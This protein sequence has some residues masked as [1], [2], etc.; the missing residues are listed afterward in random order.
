M[1]LLILCSKLKYIAEHVE[2]ICKRFFCFRH[3]C[4]NTSSSAWKTVALAVSDLPFSNWILSTAKILVIVLFYSLQMN[5]HMDVTPQSICSK[6][7]Y[8]AVHFKLSVIF[9]SVLDLIVLPR[10]LPGKLLHLALSYLSFSIWILSP[11]KRLV[12]VPFYS[13]QWTFNWILLFFMLLHLCYCNTLNSYSAVFKLEHNLYPFIHP[14][15]LIDLF[16]S[17]YFIVKKK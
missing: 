9:F 7:K 12:I 1:L 15:I 17:I 3:D 6:L 14:F 2:V 4:S 13:L 16:I 10:A 11:A 8:M 5:I